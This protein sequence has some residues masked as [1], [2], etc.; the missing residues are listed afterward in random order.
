MSALAAGFANP[1][2]ESARAFR[3]A[4]QAM[5]CPGTIQNIAGPQVPGLSAAAALLL[6]TL[7]DSTT[8][9]LL[10]GNSAEARNWLTFH[11]GAPEPANAAE[12]SFAVGTWGDLGPLK[13]YPVGTPD[14]PDRSATLIVEMSDISADGPCLTGPGI[15]T[16]VRMSLPDADALRLN[17]ALYPLGVDLF[18]T[19]GTRLAALPR[20]TRIAEDT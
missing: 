11:T 1:P 14:Y 13:A 3:A 7:T 9:V 4:M 10:T 18:L 12:A 6:L 8:P 15:E 17:A 19:S 2:E 16:E 5:A 20:S